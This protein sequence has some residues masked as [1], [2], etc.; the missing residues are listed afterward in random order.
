MSHTDAELESLLGDI[1]SDLVERKESYS[2]DTPEKVRQAVCAFANDLPDHRRAG[3]VFIGAKDSG[4]PS[5]LPITDEL[6]R[7]L[8]D[9]KTD[10][11]TLPPPSLTVQKRRLRG[12]DMAVVLVLP[13]DAPPVRCRGR[14]WIRIGP[15]RGIATA[16]EERILNEK[17]RFGDLPFDA[18]PVPTATVGDLNRRLFEEEYLPSAFARDILDANDRS[19]EQRLAACKMVA[20][21]D[22]PVP[23]I[24]GLLVLGNQPRE[25]IPGAYVQFLRIDGENLSDP[26]LDE[27][28]ID[29]PL[30]QVVRRLDDKLLS[31]NRTSVRIAGGPVE[32]RRDTYPLAALQQLTRNALM[33]RTYE[34]TNPP[35]RVSWFSDRIEIVSPGGPF[36]VVTRANFGQ[37]G[38]TD[39][40]N[41]S[42]AEAMRVLGFVQRFGVGIQLAQKEL[43]RNGQPPAIFDP[44][45]T[46]VLVTVRGAT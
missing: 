6:L 28:A 39:Y 7:S 29:G 20:A 37:P 25:W 19:L 46:A 41:P 44:Q 33:H 43:Q 21:A 16:Q 10:G 1:E 42:L 24:V 35:G 31:H 8:A 45:D 38:F 23:T 9:I 12:A 30:G 22:R 32:Q 4:T 26:I 14:I 3:A 18:Q 27:Q 13:A 34:S 36:G 40:R 17:R 2:G 11:N 5:G 15:R